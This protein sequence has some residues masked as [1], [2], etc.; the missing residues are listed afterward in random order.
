M[1][2]F[3]YETV[4]INNV[5]SNLLQICKVCTF[6]PADPILTLF[7]D[8]VDDHVYRNEGPC[9]ANASTAMTENNTL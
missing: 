5:A 1:Q 3:H 8:G 2:V 6:S 7:L 9:S 4:K